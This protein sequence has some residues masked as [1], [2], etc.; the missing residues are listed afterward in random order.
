M[1]ENTNE[2]GAQP[3]YPSNREALLQSL[4]ERALAGD[5]AAAE[6]VL[7]EPR[8]LRVESSD[9]GAA[10]SRYDVWTSLCKGQISP[11]EARELLAILEHL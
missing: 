1:T 4:T 8:R 2:S 11:P 9:E 7:R 5:M 6:L 10:P 3:P